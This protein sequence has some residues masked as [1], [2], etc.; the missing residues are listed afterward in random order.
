MT[1]GIINIRQ[2]PI[3]E[4]RLKELKADI[5][6][7]TKAA[8]DLACTEGNVKEI[9]KVR[10]DLRKECDEYETA[11]INVKKAVLAP[12]NAFEATYKTC[13][14]IPFKTADDELKRKI[15]EVEDGLKAEK[16]KRVEDFVIELRKSLNL[17]W[18]PLSRAV[19]NVTL[20]ASESALNQK[21]VEELERIYND[22]NA[23]SDPEV[24][25]EYKKSYS[26]SNAQ[27]TVANRRREIERAAE[28]ARKR[29][30]QEEIKREA[31]KKVTET[32]PV[33]SLAPP[34]QKKAPKKRCKMTFTV[35]GTID[36][37]KAL[38][39]FMISNN[40]EVSGGKQ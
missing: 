14:S 3:I 23:I 37:L 2:L 36:Q 11:R 15:A 35:I 20:S 32:V 9:K 1:D 25:A 7:R 5:E 4:E 13:V 34:V 22:V 19:P 27:I 6:S 8:M 24:L 12:Y 26:L 40:I 31:E 38:K 33:E 30:Q 29:E 21:A 39:A 28:E 16:R 17:E 18:V 10:A